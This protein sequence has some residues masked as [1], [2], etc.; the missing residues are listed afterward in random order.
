MSEIFYAFIVVPVILILVMGF[1]FQSSVV[2]I[3]EKQARLECPYPAI[4]GLW[5]SSG[6]IV[7]TNATY[8]YPNVNNQTLTLTCTEVHTLNGFDYAYGSPTVSFAGFPFFIGDW[9][10]ELFTN[11]ASAL[12]EMVV[13]FVTAPAQ[14]SALSWYIYVDVVLIAF[15]VI[16]GIM[17]IRG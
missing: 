1:I 14:I 8:N 5:N 7:Y 10:S 16:G 11:K 3:A 6:T 17:L 4:S 15:I 9:L 12:A 2:A 13:L